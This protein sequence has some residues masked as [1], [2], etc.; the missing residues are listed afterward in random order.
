MRLACA[1]NG[2]FPRALAGPANRPRK[3]RKPV[4]EMITSLQAELLLS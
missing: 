1:E 4:V 3:D 2:R